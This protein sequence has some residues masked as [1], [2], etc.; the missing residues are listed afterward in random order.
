MVQKQE[1]LSTI[2]KKIEKISI[3]S[4]GFERSLEQNSPK[5]R[6]SKEDEE[7]LEANTENVLLK[8]F[9][10]IFGYNTQ[11]LTDPN[12]AV[13]QHKVNSRRVDLA[14]FKNGQISI[15]IE[16]KGFNFNLNHKN[17]I[18]QLSEYFNNISPAPKFGILTNGLQYK[19]YASFDNNNRL[20][21]N[22]CF[23]FD[24]RTDAGNLQKL[25][26]LYEILCNI[27]EDEAKQEKTYARTREFI[28]EDILNNPTDLFIRK[29]IL[30]TAKEAGLI[31]HEG[32]IITAKDTENLKPIVKKIF[33]DI[34]KERVQQGLIQAI[35]SNNPQPTEQEVKTSKIEFTELE[36]QALL[37]IKAIASELEGFDINRITADDCQG[38]CNIILDGQARNKKLCVLYFNNP[39]KLSISL[40]NTSQPL[41][42]PSDI[43]K[44]KEELKEAIKGFI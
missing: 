32:K 25:D 42:S 36:N 16:C 11:S 7:Y 2:S 8:P 13:A 1:L 18:N 30:E 12:R 19:F 17:Y 14:L 4:Q 22:I 28:E 35:N 9:V 34:I 27:N 29:G 6:N 10:E 33:E 39:Q 24:I 20:D 43:Y 44:H 26:R 38:H 40:N 21:D 3:E 23:E 15:V 37:I 41:K 31:L 5:G